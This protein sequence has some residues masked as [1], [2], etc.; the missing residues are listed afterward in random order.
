MQSDASLSVLG[1]CSIWTSALVQRYFSSAAASQF[2]LLCTSENCG[3]VLSSGRYGSFGMDV[4]VGGW[5][6]DSSAIIQLYRV[7][8]FV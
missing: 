6:S 1:H 3:T 2:T 5:A 8:M 7:S 4:H